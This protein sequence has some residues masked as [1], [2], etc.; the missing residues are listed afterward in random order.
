M[1]QRSDEALAAEVAHGDTEA[2]RCL[3]TR[4]QVPAFNLILRLTGDRE[5]ARD[6]LQEAFTRVWTMAHT[7]DA[8]RGAF[9][10]WLYTIALNT[11]RSELARK[12]HGV[13][14]VEPQEDM[15]LAP[16]ADDPEAR[17]LRSEGR[18]RV[19]QALS[20]LS[21]PLREVVVM[22]VFHQL[23]FREIAAISRTPEGTLKAR[24]HRAVAELREHLGGRGGQP[25]D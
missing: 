11:A 12:R 1:D 15:A 9:K 21:P 10:G 5:M 16:E 8:G 4:Y 20:R 7:F 13:K 22:K 19:E 2:L 25:H 17:L 6:L 3:Y 23:K 14:H 18:R 24:F